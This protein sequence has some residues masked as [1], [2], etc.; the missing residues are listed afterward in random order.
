ME[1]GFLET[2]RQPTHSSSSIRTFS[3]SAPM[4]SAASVTRPVG[5]GV[6]LQTA[7]GLAQIT[8]ETGISKNSQRTVSGLSKNICF[9]AGCEPPGEGAFI[10]ASRLCWDSG[11]GA[12][13]SYDLYAVCVA[14]L[15][16]LI[17]LHLSESRVVYGQAHA[18]LKGRANPRSGADKPA[19]DSRTSVRGIAEKLFPVD[20]TFKRRSH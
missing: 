1:N 19:L 4:S 20:E 13:K 5:S 8:E 18:C 16:C 3:L 14:R 6:Q 9:W 10:R 2:S 12:P 15:N 11:F 17:P 7:S